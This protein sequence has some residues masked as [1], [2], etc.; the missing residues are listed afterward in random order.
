MRKTFILGTAA[1]A[2]ALTPF[3]LNTSATAQSS[4]RNNGV[5]SMDSER[6]VLTM[7]PLLERVTP[8]VV[9]IDVRGKAKPS[10]GS[11]R[12]EELLERF[13][14]GQMPE[15]QPR[16]KRGLGSGVIV[17]ASKGLIITN[18]HVIDGADEITV[19]LEDKRQLEAEVVG[20]DKKTDIALIKVSASGLKDLKLAR[21]NDVKVGDYVIAVG[22][23]FGL[24]HSVTSGIVS[25]LGRDRGGSRGGYQDFIQTDASINPGNSGGALVNSKGELIGINSAIVSRSGGNQGI[26]FAVPTNIVK[27]VMRQ[28]ESYGEVRR[29]RI[30]ILI[31]DIN[32]TLKEA[33]ELTTL[34]GALVSDVVE[35]SPAEKAGLK[36][37]D[38]IVAF[39]GG[40]I[41]DASDIR[42]AV[43]LVEP[44]ERA[45]I[46]YL[47][48]GKRRTTRIEVEAVDEDDAQTGVESVD[49]EPKSESFSGASLTDIPDDLE[50]RG[51]NEGVFVSAVK[52][53]SKAQRAGLQKGDVIRSVN[54]QDI[55]DLSDFEDIIAD[56]DGPFAMSVE[57]NG[58]T[59]YVAVK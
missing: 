17:N 50:L 12:N 44:G 15:S 48:N 11:S 19:T 7:A 8:A 42:N 56:E 33:L 16:E 27:G 4:F 18:A 35:D 46:T 52:R 41:R 37:D 45:D 23:P 30:G 2:L 59:F 51:G 3:A 49:D 10:Q 9:S 38:V 29:G 55:T 1:I 28:L 32:P 53:G 20:S 57:R 13:F 26:G 31:G 6:G 47:R 24:S 22:N 14:G 25:A 54:R 21:A 58:S 34:D 43:G 39:N 36:R 5:M 40:D